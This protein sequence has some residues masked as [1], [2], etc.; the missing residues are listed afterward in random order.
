M[1]SENDNNVINE[2]I[3]LAIRGVASGS[4]HLMKICPVHNLP[5][6]YAPNPN[7]GIKRPTDEVIVVHWIE[8]YASHCTEKKKSYCT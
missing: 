4:D 5:I 8:L 6:W 3:N 1:R 2:V 7:L